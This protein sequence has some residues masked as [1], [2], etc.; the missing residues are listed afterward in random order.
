MVNGE[1]GSYSNSPF[2]YS[3]EDVNIM[4][5]YSKVAGSFLFTSLEDVESKL[6]FNMP[7]FRCVP[8]SQIKLIYLIDFEPTSVTLDRVTIDSCTSYS[9]GQIFFERGAFSAEINESFLQN[10]NGMKGEADLRVQQLEDLKIYMSF[11]KHSI[12]ICKTS[13]SILYIKH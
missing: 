13:K 7:N 11:F 6:C 4:S 3:F 12:S 10:N 1:A 8:Y 5:S 9:V 2:S